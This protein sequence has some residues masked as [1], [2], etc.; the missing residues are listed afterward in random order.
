M[1][2][3]SHYLK[4]KNKYS[5]LKLKSDT[6]LEEELETM[7]IGL[8]ELQALM[9]QED[10]F[11]SIGEELEKHMYHSR[12]LYLNEEVCSQ[13]IDY[14]TQL[15][16][17]WN[18]EDD[19]GEIPVEDRI[20]I[21]IHISSGGGDLLHGLTLVGAID[22]SVTPV[23]TVSEGGLCASMAFIIFISGHVRLASKFTDFMYHTL[24][25]QMEQSNLGTMRNTIEYYERLQN[26]LDKYILE[27]TSIPKETLD[28]KKNSSQDW[29]IDSDLIE[30]YGIAKLIL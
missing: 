2:K 13:T 25:S 24:I 12:T 10:T 26:K 28:Q 30:E 9:L 5:Y 15:I 14:M 1:T 3:L 6:Q 4:G 18:Y 27:K 29:F 23:F 17:K 16:H 20:P 11:T 7:E 22:N 8:D 21:F 19:M